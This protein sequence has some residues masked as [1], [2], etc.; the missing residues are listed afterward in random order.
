LW[1]IFLSKRFMMQFFKWRRTKR[2]DLM[3]FRLS[4]I[5]NFGMSL[6]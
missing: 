5:K 3:A 6:K 1:Q 4:F 2:R